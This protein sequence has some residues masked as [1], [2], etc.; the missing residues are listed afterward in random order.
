MNP[1]LS[2]RDIDFLLYELHDVESLTKLPVF[3]E[4]SRETFD[5]LLGSVRRL[6]R[7]VLFPRYRAMDQAAPVFENGRMRVHP[8]MRALYGQMVE[9]GLINASSPAQHGGQD[10]P[11][12]INVVASTYL[13]AANTTAYGYM[14]LT[15][16]AAH[17]LETFGSDVLK[18]RFMKPMHEGRFT[19]T[20]ALT[21]PQAGSSL[22][23]VKSKATPKPDG[24]FSISG[25][26]I[27]ISGGDNDFAENTVHLTLARIDGAPAGTK[28]ISLFAIPRL[29][30]KD[31]KLVDNDV[32]VAGAIHKL[33]ARGIPSCVLNFG[34]RG[35]C[36][37]FLVG[38]PH[39]GLACM[40]QMMN[41][42][43]ILVG[44]GAA[45]TASAAYHASI[46]Y[47]H[48]RAQG[49]SPSERDP[50]KPPLAIIEHADV[51]RMLLRQKAIVEG[52][53]ALIVLCGKLSD[54]ALHGNGDDKARAQSLLD[55]LTPIAKTFPS[56]HGFE[57]NAL[58]VQVHGGYGYS[59][60]FLVEA[61]LRDQKLNTLHEG[62]TGI[63]SL[64]LLGRKVVARGGEALQILAR[65]VSA[66]IAGAR[67]AG[68]DSAW[69]EAIEHA[70][71]DVAETT[72]QLGALGAAGD[73][74]A[75]LRHSVDYLEMVSIVVVAWQWLAMATLAK[76]KLASVGVNG[77][78]A[79]F[80]EGKLCAAQYWIANE[81]PRVTTLAALCRSNDDSYARMKPEWF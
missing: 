12:V 23:D 25:T 10:L 36:T 69:C 5:L 20:M 66:T 6:A 39:K 72:M 63:Q 71:N 2:D 21:E 65:D 53:L 15:S 17:L 62:T 16:G 45:G 70:V 3:A 51:R 7:D 27:F 32:R 50:N 75:M 47:A 48:D 4:H 49:R 18:E 80:Y 13:M 37:G 77:D 38:E 58:A 43:R 68:V 56:E 40:F 31:G 33:G 60:E 61:W 11:V 79:A 76:A 73:V 28:G 41:E 46:T 64:D 30:P 35:E 74:D 52:S 24:S 57:A 42:A 67:A 29:L 55:L 1:L 54:T 8:D 14:G 22:A 44:A 59:S 81:V 19:G 78:D 26:K 34:E 9:L